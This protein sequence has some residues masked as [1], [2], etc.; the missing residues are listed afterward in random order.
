MDNEISKE[1]RNEIEAPDWGMALDLICEII[2]E[3][4]EKNNA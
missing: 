4:T 1:I 2:N 3:I